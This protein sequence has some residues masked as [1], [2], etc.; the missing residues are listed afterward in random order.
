MADQQESSAE[1]FDVEVGNDELT[2]GIIDDVRGLALP[3]QVFVG[4]LG[5]EN[6]G[7]R[8][9]YFTP[10]LDEG[11][12]FPVSQAR[13]RRLK[14]SDRFPMGAAVVWL[15]EDSDGPTYFKYDAETAIE[16][17]GLAIPYCTIVDEEGSTRQVRLTD[18]RC[19]NAP[20]TDRYICGS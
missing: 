9:L 5:S 6:N 12:E 8:R 11:I 20:R 19:C 13:W 18:Y 16:S 4:F 17:T 1:E 3:L 2:E 10:F 15:H 7:F 14:P